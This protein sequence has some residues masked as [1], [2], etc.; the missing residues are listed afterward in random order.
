MNVRRFGLFSHGRTKTVQSNAFKP[1]CTANDSLHLCD[2][3]NFT[4]VLIRVDALIRTK[5]PADIKSS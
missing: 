4:D 3:H 2:L 1:A 5:R